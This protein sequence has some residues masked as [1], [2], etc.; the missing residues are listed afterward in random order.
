MRQ[1]Q[2]RS[3]NLAGID[4]NLLVVLE[5]LLQEA[6]VTRAGE[7][8][9]LSQPAVS[10]TLQRLRYLFDDQLLERD[11]RH[12]RLTAR[13]H[14]LKAPLAD[15]LDDL[16][17]LLLIPSTFDPLTANVDLRIFASDY[18]TAVLLPELRRCLTESAPNIRVDFTSADR[19][20]VG[21]LLQ[22]G[23]IDFAIG[24]FE[25]MGEIVRRT[26][27]FEDRI[28]LVARRGHPVLDGDL[29]LDRMTQYPRLGV[30][31]NG[32]A[33]SPTER[34][35]VRAGGKVRCEVLIQ[36]AL[37]GPATLPDTDLV[38]LTS[39]RLTNSLS[40]WLP[41]AWREPPFLVDTVRVELLWLEYA[42]QN[43]AIVWFRDLL[44]SVAATL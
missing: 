42:E 13:A 30:S 15:V 33:Y 19:A 5:A 18:A 43:P 23:Q 17:Q 8:V 24:M 21:E 31:F 3:I 16:R 22:H 25:N 10:N 29:T 6:N 26:T 28:V 32:R 38:M 44:L 7:R 27:L 41:I 37:I 36:D 14:S 34:A 40:R 35:I 9:G 20:K 2:E 39:E 11:G 1:L 12:M 4:L